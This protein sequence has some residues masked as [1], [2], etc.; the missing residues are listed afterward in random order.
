[1]SGPRSREASPAWEAPSKERL[2]S[3]GGEVERK[4]AGPE[5]SPVIQGQA[6]QYARCPGK[7]LGGGGRAL[8]LVSP[9][10]G[11]YSP[12][13]LIKQ[14]R[15]GGTSHRRELWDGWVPCTVLYRVR[16]CVGEW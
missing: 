3:G 1:M 9:D 11:E 5:G 14:E 16:S 7:K 12:Q 6:P 2:A 8:T 10:S 13:L 15:D 4:E